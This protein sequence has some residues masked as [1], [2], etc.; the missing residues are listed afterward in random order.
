MRKLAYTIA[1]V[2]VAKTMFAQNYSGGT[3]SAS[4]TAGYRD[5]MV[6]STSALKIKEMLTFDQVGGT[7]RFLANEWVPG[8]GI[9]YYNT[10]TTTGYTFNYD[11]WKKELYVK[12]GDTAII[13]DNNYLKSFYVTVD[14]EKH[15]FCRYQALGTA[16][17]VELLSADTAQAKLKLVKMRT[18]TI[19]RNDKSNS[20]SNLMGDFKD[21]FTSEYAYYLVFP[22]DTAVKIKMNSKAFLEGLKPGYTAKAQELLKSVKKVNETSLKQVVNNINRGSSI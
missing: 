3:G 17:L 16:E 6:Q 21:H 19:Q 14:N 5:F 20:G 1:L 11:F 12:W 22:D 7:E 4:M 8:A 13:A 10:V 9:N 18:T 2:L 15:T